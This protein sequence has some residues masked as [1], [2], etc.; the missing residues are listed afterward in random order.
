MRRSKRGCAARWPMFHC[1]R[2]YGKRSEILDLS[3]P[4]QVDL[5]KT[6]GYLL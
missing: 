1:G 6:S 2:E 4:L 5:M 3:E